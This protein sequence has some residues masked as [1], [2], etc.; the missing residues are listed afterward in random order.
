MHFSDRHSSEDGLL[1]KVLFYS[2]LL[3]Y[4]LVY[5]FFGNPFLLLNPDDRPAV[6][7]QS[8]EVKLLNF[9]KNLPINLPTNSAINEETEKKALVARA[10]RKEDFNQ[11]PDATDST[12]RISDETP[13]TEKVE[14]ALEQPQPLQASELATVKKVTVK[15]PPNMTGPEDCMLKLVGMVCPQGKIG[16]I[17]A[18]RDFC[19]SLPD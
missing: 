11:S 9:P 10:L 6:S 17:T 2:V 15:M 1:P 12:R 19:A 3:H 7:A 8:F 16:C 4:A 18:Y 13:N 5:L 14:E